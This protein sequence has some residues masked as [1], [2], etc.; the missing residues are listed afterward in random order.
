MYVRF[1]HYERPEMKYEKLKMVL[2]QCG[3]IIFFPLYNN[4]KCY[5]IIFTMNEKKATSML[6]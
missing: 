1:P 6:K 4:L 5:Y 2:W 3:I